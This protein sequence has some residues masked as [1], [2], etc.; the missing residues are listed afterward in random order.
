M[1]FCPRRIR[2]GQNLPRLQVIALFLRL[3]HGEG[4]AGQDAAG[5][6]AREEAVLVDRREPEPNTPGLMFQ[7]TECGIAV[8]VVELAFI[9]CQPS[10]QFSL[11][12]RQ[13]E[14]CRFFRR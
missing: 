12:N 3:T 8:D 10:V 1:E 13:R 5:E 2:S 4:L 11:K 9:L 6:D 14:A 7:S